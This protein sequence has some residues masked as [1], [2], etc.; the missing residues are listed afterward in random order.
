M[1]LEA[2]ELE[3]GQ[4]QED[5]QLPELLTLEAAVE[6]DLVTILQDLEVLV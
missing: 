2:V 6:L 1:E 5:K 3:H 4:T